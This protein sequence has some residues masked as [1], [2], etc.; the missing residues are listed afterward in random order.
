M[1]ETTSEIRLEKSR[2]RRTELSK[3]IFVDVY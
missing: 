1:F 2:V 3:F